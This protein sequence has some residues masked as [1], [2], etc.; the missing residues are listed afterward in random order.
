MTVSNC[1]HF[2]LCLGDQNLFS[3]LL[4][5]GGNLGQKAKFNKGKGNGNTSVQKS[6]A[7]AI[8]T[9]T[10]ASVAAA[11]G[12]EGIPSEAMTIR[13]A[14]CAELLVNDCALTR[15]CP[16]LVSCPR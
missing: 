14:K 7:D 4:L 10:V 5:H 3:P 15:R 8:S 13:E 11:H 2:R 16:S 6:A 9:V 12:A 1:D